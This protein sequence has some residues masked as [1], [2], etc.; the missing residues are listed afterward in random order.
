[1]DLK[2]VR[3]LLTSVLKIDVNGLEV[4]IA[5][6]TEKE[7]SAFQGDCRIYETKDGKV[8]DLTLKLFGTDYHYVDTFEELHRIVIMVSNYVNVEEKKMALT[9]YNN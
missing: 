2:I 8:E 1:M 4:S 7:G 9:I 3:S 6:D 5:Y